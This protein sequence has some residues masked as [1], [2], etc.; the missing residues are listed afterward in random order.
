MKYTKSTID[1]V[2]SI[3]DISLGLIKESIEEFNTLL[4]AEVLEEDDVL[5]IANENQ[6]R[7]LMNALSLSIVKKDIGILEG[8][9]NYIEEISVTS[10]KDGVKNVA[11]KVGSR[12]KSGYYLAKGA[13]MN[14][15]AAIQ[16]WRAKKIR[17]KAINGKDI[18]QRLANIR[19]ANKIEASAKRLKQSAAE[20]R[21]AVKKSASS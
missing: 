17:G 3:H 5:F 12:V 16:G 11:G 2:K 6:H 21:E 14:K 15:A 4:E 10:I 20:A 1:A 8:A 19:K 9:I 18:N 7:I 13:L